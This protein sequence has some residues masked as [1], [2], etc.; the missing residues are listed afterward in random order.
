VTGIYGMNFEFMP[1]LKSPHGYYIVLGAMA[2]IGVTMFLI[3]K[4]KEWL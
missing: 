2:T 1:E 4:R 3:F